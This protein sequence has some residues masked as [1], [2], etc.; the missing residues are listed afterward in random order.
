MNYFRR[1]YFLFPGF[2]ILFASCV[3]LKQPRNKINF[4]T[5]EYSLPQTFEH[6]PLPFVIRIVRF[7]VAPLYNTR[8]MIY[9]DSSFT[10]DAYV[11]HKWRASPGSLVTYF[12]SRDMKESRLF[13]AVLPNDSGFP[14][15]YVVE[16]TVDE[17]FELDTEEDWKAVLTLNITLMAENEPDISKRILSQKTY[18]TMKACKQ[19]NPRALAEAMSEAMAEVSG[20]IIKDIYH[21]LKD[22]QQ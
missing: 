1:I 19:K 12:L 2:F 22:Y 11:S 15:S 13:K 17:F 8:H 4:Y 9:R 7:S 5:F 6:N 16:G 14:S 18:H 10:R 21:N 3:D 20:T